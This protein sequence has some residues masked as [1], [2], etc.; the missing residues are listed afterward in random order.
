MDDE[1][2]MFLT[3]W[4]FIILRVV[5]IFEQWEG[6]RQ[7]DNQR[8]SWNPKERGV[9][10]HLVKVTDPSMPFF[11]HPSLASFYH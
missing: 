4:Y 7:A 1:T 5:F 8:L 10:P 6:I 9:T 2:T 3:L 11:L